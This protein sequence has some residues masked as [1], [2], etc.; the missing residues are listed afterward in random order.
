MVLAAV[1][2]A[3]GI[4][5]EVRLR[6]F[7]ESVESLG[8]HR[9]FQA[10]ERTLTLVAVRPGPHGP[11][12]RFAEVTDRTAAEALKGVEL[13]VPRSALPPPADDEVYWVDLM[14]RGVVD[15]AGRPVGTVVAVANYGA[16]DLIEVELA[17][18]RRVLV[19]LIPEAARVEDDR[20]CVDPLWLEA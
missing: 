8:R 16:S 17:G 12:A 4:H 10:G 6:L 20:I 11:I 19:P 18:G 3:H 5:G 14:G 2:G 9:S 13:A 1:A 7:A 15:P